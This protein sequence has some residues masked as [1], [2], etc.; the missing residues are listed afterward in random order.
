MIFFQKRRTWLML[1]WIN[2]F[3]VTDFLKHRNSKKIIIAG[4]II[5]KKF[6]FVCFTSRRVTIGLRGREELFP[7]YILRN[8]LS[9][10]LDFSLFLYIS[11]NLSV[12][13]SFSLYL[14]LCTSFFTYNTWLIH[15]GCSRCGKQLVSFFSSD[16]VSKKVLKR[17]N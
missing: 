5:S 3:D 15:S 1:K 10:S 7:L 14:S 2:N 13:L 9:I 11:F 8:F 6:S 16:F 17:I 4:W 12:P